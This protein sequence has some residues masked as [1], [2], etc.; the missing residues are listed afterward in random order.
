MPADQAERLRRVM[1]TSRSS[2]AAAPPPPQAPG[3]QPY[4]KPIGGPAKVLGRALYEAGR[5]GKNV[6][7]NAVAI[8]AM[9]AGATT[10]AY[11][12][13]AATSA[14]VRGI[15]RLLGGQRPAPA[16]QAE[17]KSPP[18]AEPL[19]APPDYRS[20]LQRAIDQKRNTPPAG[21]RSDVIR[22]LQTIR[23]LS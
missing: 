23:G 19:P 20:G 14:A 11:A 5:Q 3:N 18:A 12:G 17:P 16:P 1:Q 2:A 15:N 4:F 10:G 6:A 22:R 21:I 9:A 8:P 7:A 13:L